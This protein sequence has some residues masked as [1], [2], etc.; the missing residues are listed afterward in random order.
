MTDAAH[1]LPAQTSV[2][3]RAVTRLIRRVRRDDNYVVDPAISGADLVEEVGSRAAMLLRAQWSLRGVRG[4]RLR[5]AEP[6]A[7]I[8]FR[9]HC[10]IG[11]GSVVE[12]HARLRCLSHDGVV[13]GRRVT[14]G[15]YAILECSGQLARLGK[16]ISIGDY[17]SVGDYSFIGAAGGVTIGSR[18]MMGQRVAIHSQNHNFA[19][20]SVPIQQQGTTQLG[21]RIE[22][23]CWIGSG[24]VILDGVTVGRG[25]VLSAGSVVTKDVPSGSVIGGVPAK[26][27]RSRW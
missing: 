10:T 21:V 22:D 4:S 1:P 16:G 8:S 3:N 7:R 6:G 11:K 27:L 13:I 23:D 9:K 20:T 26:V 17:S 19:D 15:K 12:A 18:V 24:V 14:I 5:F 2:A 25:S